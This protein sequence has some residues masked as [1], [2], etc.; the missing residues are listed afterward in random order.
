MT[1]TQVKQQTT[2][3][4]RKGIKEKQGMGLWE[5]EMKVFFQQHKVL[6]IVLGRSK[7]E[8]TSLHSGC[9]I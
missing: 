4:T 7:S 3:S 5:E 9:L 6:S 1:R 8:W 2:K